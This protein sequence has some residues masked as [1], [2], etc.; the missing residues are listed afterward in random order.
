MDDVPSTWQDA[1]LAARVLAAA[2]PRLGGI[3]VRARAGPARDA[4]LGYFQS[5]MLARTPWKRVTPSFP[6][7]ALIGGLDIA[8]TL[9]TGAP[10]VET[11]LLARADGGVVVMAMA[12]RT[13]PSMAA[14]VGAALDT[15]IVRI[16]RDGVSACAPARITFVA[17]DEGID[18]DEQ[19]PT[20]LSDRLALSIDL[21]TVGWR[22]AGDLDR[23]DRRLPL[24]EEIAA[25]KIPDDVE[26]ALAGVA[27]LAGEVSLRR[28]I[29]LIHVARTIAALDGRRA[30]EPAHAGAAVR[31][32]L[33]VLTAGEQDEDP[34]DAADDVP[35]PETDSQ[36][37]DGDDRALDLDALQDLLIAAESAALPAELDISR[38]MPRRARANRANA[39]KSGAKRKNA[40]RGRPVGVTA[41]PPY[42]GARINVLATLRTA[43]L[44]QQIRR[45]ERAVS[46][47]RP[48][49]RLDIR[50]SDF[51]YTRFK[52]ETESTAILTVDASGS[53]ALDRLG[54][55]KGAAEL[56]LAE[57]YVRRD[58]VALIAFRGRAAEV[59]LPPTRSLV[60]AKRS[61]AAVPGG[62]GTPLASGMISAFE[63]ANAVRH[64]GHS[65]LVVLMTDGSANIALDGLPGRE[66]AA[67]DAE[68]IARHYAAAGM[69]AIVIDIGR[70]PSER[71]AV[72]AR[73]MAADYHALPRADA[74][75]VSA[76]VAGYMQ[77]G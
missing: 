24:V 7:G 47:R 75:T 60:R 35:P 17:L 3:R 11:G 18:T 34:D 9:E 19:L 63:L 49:G 54:E 51:R 4:W 70:R 77:A 64:H 59:L 67:R 38:A 73:M 39:G 12:E 31:L 10:A 52:H 32:V 72:L 61:L 37:S 2:G 29:F 6:E 74:Q 15:G 57:C 13:T 36:P 42:P 68:T 30:V 25:V 65:P 26:R 21:S 14:L 55:A 40:R 1:L 44:W 28:P 56:L 5:L 33:P 43:A 23:S 50:K 69:A 45:R 66:A 62:G 20:A 71:T 76:V 41:K 8:A 58:N 16:E 27:L 48:P 22:E 53:T 46:G